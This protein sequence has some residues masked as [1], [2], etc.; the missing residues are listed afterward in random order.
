M[1]KIVI[2]KALGIDV[3]DLPAWLFHMIKEHSEN[4]VGIELLLK[5]SFEM[6][7]GEEVVDEIQEMLSTVT[8]THTKDGDTFIINTITEAVAEEVVLGDRGPVNTGGVGDAVEAGADNDEE[9][10]A[11]MES[12]EA[13]MAN[14]VRTVYENGDDEESTDDADDAD[15]E[16]AADDENPRVLP[17]G[18]FVKF[19]E[20][21]IVIASELRSDTTNRAKEAA[22]TVK[23]IGI[24]EL[25]RMSL[26]RKLNR[27]M[28]ILDG[29]EYVD[30]I[31]KEIIRVSS[32]SKVID[33]VID[34]D[35]NIRIYLKPIVT[36]EDVMRDNKRYDIGE[37]VIIIPVN[38]L[39]R[40]DDFTGCVS[41]QNIT[42]TRDDY[43][44][45]HICGTEP[46]FGNTKHNIYESLV[47]CELT[48]LVDS[49]YDL[50]RNPDFKDPYGNKARLFPVHVEEEV[51][52]DTVQTAQ[53]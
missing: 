1:N 13:E 18:E 34:V 2:K 52:V 11:E 12:V 23:E 41:I 30:K 5:Q 22:D 16:A 40:D 9:V 20:R 44:A 14:A 45:P 10:V 35:K 48:I 43:D 25:K 50:I 15:D 38:I 32:H 31:A 42:R 28:L 24:L 27:L 7:F 51:A 33:C 6:D 19:N 37:I 29:N 36:V 49:V 3:D 47:N 46:C 26:Q 4:E 17:D 39:A 21:N 53:G 8:I